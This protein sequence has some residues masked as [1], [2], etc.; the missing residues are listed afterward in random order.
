[1]E[2]LLLVSR[3]RLIR[4]GLYDSNPP[5]LILREDQPSDE[6]VE[7][8]MEDLF[9]KVRSYLKEKYIDIDNNLPKE[10]QAVRL[11]GLYERNV[12]SKEE[13]DALSF[14]MKYE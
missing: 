6:E 13:Y 4:I 8:F 1:L 10:E 5:V 2:F 9:T 12:L 7:K 11:R 3:K 14:K